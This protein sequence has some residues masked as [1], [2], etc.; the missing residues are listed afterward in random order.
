MGDLLAGGAPG[1]QICKSVT[2]GGSTCTRLVDELVESP[3]FVELVDSVDAVRVT[4]T[5]GC[6][7][8]E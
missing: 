1:T 2:S 4:N 7:E 6:W 5:F 8:C 3:E